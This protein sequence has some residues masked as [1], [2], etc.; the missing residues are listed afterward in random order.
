MT[1]LVFVD[2]SV[3]LYRRDPTE[4]VKRPLA[5]AWLEHVWR[6][7]TG[8][9]SCQVL[10][11]YYTNATRKLRPGLD[12]D[13]AWDDVEALQ[14][15]RP[16]PLDAEL[17]RLGRAIE[18]RYRLSWWDSLIVASAQSQNC[19]ILLTE[20]LQ[21][22]V[23]FDGVTVRSPFTLSVNEAAAEYATRPA[24]SRHPPRGRPRKYPQTRPLQGA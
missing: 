16:Q 18:R 22:G 4:P 10:S 15:W 20:D 24:P 14:S 12:L 21:D 23:Y 3:L 2:S 1:A 5:T 11:E 7:Q 8:R 17:L 9:I 19:A 13:E 6:Q